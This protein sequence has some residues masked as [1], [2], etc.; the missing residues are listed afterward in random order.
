[1]FGDIVVKEAC[2]PSAVQNC[3]VR[4]IIDYTRVV[5]E[6]K[7]EASQNLMQSEFAVTHDLQSLSSAQPFL[8][9]LC[10]ER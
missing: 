9:F 10:R 8:S 3:D 7:K 4:T 1:M 6:K 5:K 2:L